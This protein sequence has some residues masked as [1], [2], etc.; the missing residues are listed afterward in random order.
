[1][2]ITNQKETTMNITL[3]GKTLKQVNEFKYLGSIIRVNNSS[4]TDIKR[5]LGLATGAFDKLDKVWRNKKVR[6]TTKI[7]LVLPVA[8]YGCETWARTQNEDTRIAAFEMKCL[9]GF[10]TSNGKRKF[11]TRKYEQ[12]LT[13]GSAKTGH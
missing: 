11:L 5:R 1:M 2:V 9:G 13:N 8:L 12:K 10:S 3:K 7:R 6:L 4:A